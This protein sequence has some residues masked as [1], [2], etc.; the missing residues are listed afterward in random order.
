MHQICFQYLLVFLATKMKKIVMDVGEDSNAMLAPM[1]SSVK[2]VI[3]DG[4][5]LQ[6]D[7]LHFFLL[8]R[9]FLKNW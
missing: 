6:L 8:L 7:F 5:F 3:V 4:H 2:I 1:I 9:L